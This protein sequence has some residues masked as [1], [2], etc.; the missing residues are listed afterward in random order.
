MSDVNFNLQLYDFPKAIKSKDRSV[1]VY[2]YLFNYEGGLNMLKKA[3]KLIAPASCEIA[4][5]YIF[6]AAPGSVQ[7]IMRKCICSSIGACHADELGYLFK[8]QNPAFDVPEEAVHRETNM[9]DTL[10]R[11]WTNFAKYGYG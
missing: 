5:T 6:D 4:G 10:C 8:M 7:S 9:I 3:C 1:P 11:F 2:V